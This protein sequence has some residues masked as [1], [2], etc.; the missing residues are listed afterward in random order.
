MTQET[1]QETLA[2][3]VERLGLSI[4]AEFVPWSK[5]RKED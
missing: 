1:T 4:K 2:E 3:A 5:S